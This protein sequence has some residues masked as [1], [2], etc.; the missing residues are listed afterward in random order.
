M[1]CFQIFPPSLNKPVKR[2]E[3]VGRSRV[4]LRSCDSRKGVPRLER[5]QMVHKRDCGAKRRRQDHCCCAEQMARILQTVNS[6]LLYHVPPVL[7][8]SVLSY[9][10]LSV[11]L[12]YFVVWG[13]LLWSALLCSAL[14]FLLFRFERLQA[15]AYMPR[16][17]KVIE[18]IR[19]VL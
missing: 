8:C 7:F 11:M 15:R 18:L 3:V 5:G 2:K 10:F 12:C 1:S 4:L 14:L 9:P 16:L 17:A 6:V 19:I 13:G